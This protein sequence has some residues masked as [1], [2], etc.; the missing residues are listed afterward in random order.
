MGKLYRFIYIR[1]GLDDDG[2]RYFLVIIS[3]GNSLSGAEGFS[4]QLHF[5]CR[6]SLIGEPG[7]WNHVT[8]H[9]GCGALLAFFLKGRVAAGTAFII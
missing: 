9:T 1:Q 2:L 3:D 8:I 5:L 6:L 7:W 4:G